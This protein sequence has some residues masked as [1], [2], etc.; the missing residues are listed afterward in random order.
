MAERWE[1]LTVAMASAVI[2]MVAFSNVASLASPPSSLSPSCDSLSLTRKNFPTL[3]TS[4]QF[5]CGRQSVSDGRLSI[6]VNGYRF[7][8]GKSVDWQCPPGIQNGSSTSCTISEFLLL[9]NAT[10][11]NV[12]GGNTSVGPSFGVS[13]SSTTGPPVGNGAELGANALFPGQR[14]GSS[15]PSQN[16]GVYLP[17]GASA[18]Y[19]LIFLPPSVN[20]SSARN[21]SLQYL[22]FREVHYGGIWQG[23]GGFACG[24]CETPNVELIVVGGA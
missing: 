15:I 11:K 20:Q 7:A 21:L 23:G 9:V 12:G 6:T 24:P 16:G 2:V 5:V 18:S 17:P 3:E 10:I 8:D 1:L 22:A 19:W 14:P 4:F 13:M